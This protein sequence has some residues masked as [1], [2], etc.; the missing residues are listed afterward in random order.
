MKRWESRFLSSGSK[1]GVG[2]ILQVIS[3]DTGIVEAVRRVPTLDTGEGIVIEDILA[4]TATVIMV[5]AA[6]RGVDVIKF[7]NTR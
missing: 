3:H 1:S 6:V 2:I 5:G 7:E 4:A